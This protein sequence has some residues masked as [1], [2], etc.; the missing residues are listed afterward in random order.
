MLTACN[1]GVV[2]VHL[3][4]ITHPGHRYKDQC[5]KKVYPDRIYLLYYQLN[6]KG[7]HYLHL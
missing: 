1:C 2:R 6:L 3:Q 7:S 4:T 5:P